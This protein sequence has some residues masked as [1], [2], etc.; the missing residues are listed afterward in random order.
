MSLRKEKFRIS[1]TKRLDLLP[2]DEDTNQAVLNVESLDKKDLLEFDL[3]AVPKDVEIEINPRHFVLRPG[4]MKNVRL[5]TEFCG[6]TGECEVELHVRVV[7]EETAGSVKE[8]KSGNAH[9]DFRKSAKEELPVVKLPLVLDKNF[10]P[11]RLKNQHVLSLGENA[12]VP[13]ENEG[14]PDEPIG[15]DT[16]QIPAEASG[17]VL[18]VNS[19]DSGLDTS[20]WTPAYFIP[21]ALGLVIILILFDKYELY[22]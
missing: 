8:A 1:P 22:K 15:E 17:N 16:N 12:D 7:K 21:L 20:L 10:T 4:E 11:R 13:V 3:K 5:I 9:P 6:D 14:N 18:K 2:H 19:R